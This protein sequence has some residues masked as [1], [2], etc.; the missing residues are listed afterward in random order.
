MATTIF[1][2]SCRRRQHNDVVLG[3]VC[4]TTVNTNSN[5]YQSGERL[6]ATEINDNIRFV[7]EDLPPSYS[8]V[9]KTKGNSHPTP[10][11]HN[12]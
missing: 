6:S 3:Q 5:R 2:S 12:A 11:H 4:T 9:I 7:L 10:I 8:E 1:D